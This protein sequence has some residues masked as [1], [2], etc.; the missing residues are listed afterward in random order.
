M[1]NYKYSLFGASAVI[2]IACSGSDVDDSPVETYA[3][4]VES[5]EINLLE[6]YTVGLYEDEYSLEE[7][8][9]ADI[10]STQGEDIDEV[11]DIVLQDRRIQAFTFDRDEVFDLFAGEPVM[12]QFDR[13]EMIE[14]NDWEDLKIKLPLMEDRLFVLSKWD[15]DSLRDGS[16][17]LASNVIGADVLISRTGEVA[18][19]EDVIFDK[20]GRITAYFVDDGLGAT[21]YRVPVSLL[22]R[23]ET[24]AVLGASETRDYSEDGYEADENIDIEQDDYL[25]DKK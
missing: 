2:L 3:P 7:F 24:Q 6:S 25:P 11:D 8:L 17:Q 22:T 23:M 9:D 14:S 18:E 16:L 13:V 20:T 15:E 21:P 10:L 5:S 1:K 19:I 4:I 12:M